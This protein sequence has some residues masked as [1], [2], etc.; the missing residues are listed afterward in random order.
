MTCVNV[1]YVTKNQISIGS[2]RKCEIAHRPHCKKLLTY[3]HDVTK[4]GNFRNI[5]AFI[6][7]TY[8]FSF[9]LSVLWFF[10]SWRNLDLLDLL[11]LLQTSFSWKRDALDYDTV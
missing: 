10:S 3:I 8:R 4:L 11:D 6:R 1:F 5:Q 9:P 2:D 7:L